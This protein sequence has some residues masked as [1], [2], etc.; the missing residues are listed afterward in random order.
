MRKYPVLHPFLFSILSVVSLFNTNKQM[1]AVGYA[2]RPALIILVLVFFLL[3]ILWFVLKSWYLASLVES[4]LMILFFSYGHIY[5]TLN[6]DKISVHP[7]TSHIVLFLSFIFMG[8][9]LVWII[10]RTQNLAPNITTIFNIVAIA[11]VAIPIYNIIIFEI[12]DK[13]PWLSQD[14]FLISSAGWNNELNSSEQPDIY[15]I[16]LDGYGRADVLEEMYAFN[17][18]SF[19]QFLAERGFFIA[20]KSMSNYSQTHLSL[21]SSLNMSY[22]DFLAESLGDQSTDHYPITRLV[23]H[24]VVRRILESYG[25]QVIAF[26]TGYR[27]TELSDANNYYT[28]PQRNINQFESMLLENSAAVFLQELLSEIGLWDWYPGYKAHR[29]MVLFTLE[30]LASLPSSRGPKF[31]FVHI[32]IPHPPFVFGTLGEEV[33][34]SHPFRTTDGNQFLGT[35]EEYITG[36]RDQIS[37]TNKQLEKVI[38]TILNLSERSPIIFLQADHG[39]GSMLDWDD[40]ERTNFKE[41]MSIL[42][43]YYIPNATEAPFY[44][45]ITPVNSFRLMFNHVFSADYE[46]LPDQSFYSSWR[47]PYQFIQVAENGKIL[48]DGE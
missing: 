11:A 43:A 2:I 8:V 10:I 21:A 22:L 16:I 19:L 6:L 37:F 46:M 27:R 12:R 48:T 23:R 36:Y 13:R 33:P 1:I 7:M 28:P 35:R 20:H 38:D 44:P 47:Y 41:R 17:N 24:S 18:N 4:I 42:N 45:S 39:P 26:A 3:I 34:Q 14:D 9:I 40:P 25:Y 32:Y 31:V 15:Y 30:R 29:E 5:Q